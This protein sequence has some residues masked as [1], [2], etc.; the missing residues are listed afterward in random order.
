MPASEREPLL[1]SR[2][3]GGPDGRQRGAGVARLPLGS[4]VVRASGVPDLYHRAAGDRQSCSGLQRSSH[5]SHNVSP[6]PEELG[7]RLS[8]LPP[9]PRAERARGRQRWTRDDGCGGF[10][11]G[12]AGGCRPSLRTCRWSQPCSACSS[13]STSTPSSRRSV[14]VEADPMAHRAVRIAP[15]PEPARGGSGVPA[16]RL[17]CARAGARSRPMGRHE[18]QLH[19][20]LG[21]A[22]HGGG[23]GGTA[24]LRL[25]MKAQGGPGRSAVRERPLGCLRRDGFNWRAARC[26]LS[27][28]APDAR[29]RLHGRYRRAARRAA[30]S[31]RVR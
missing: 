21:G 20:L 25:L 5:V 9:A 16:A 28:R 22:G 12:A 8:S 4:G 10:A 19:P 13:L 30:R 29:P 14:D 27:K 18:R 2:A 7:L 11:T 17:P 6:F 26:R 23:G 31:P 3:A 1:S 15:Q 24:G